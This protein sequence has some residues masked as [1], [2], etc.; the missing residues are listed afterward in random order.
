[1]I[2]LDAAIQRFEYS[3][4]VFWKFTKEYLRV[5]EGIVCNSPKSCFKESFKVNLITEEET[6]LALEMTDDRNM[7]AHTYHEEVAEEIYGRIKGYYS[8]MDNVSKKLF[9]LT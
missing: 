7:T 6:V 4:E 1:M 9:E 3:F 5:K 2:L 8:L